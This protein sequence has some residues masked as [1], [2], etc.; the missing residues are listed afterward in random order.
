MYTVFHLANFAPSINMLLARL[1]SV[2]FIFLQLEILSKSE[3]SEVNTVCAA[4]PV[5]A[6]E[7]FWVQMFDQ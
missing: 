2:I 7:E 6:R 3:S 4:G 1:S 5:F